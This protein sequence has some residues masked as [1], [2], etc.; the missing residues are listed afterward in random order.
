MT[1]HDAPPESFRGRFPSEPGLEGTFDGIPG[2]PGLAIGKAVVLVRGGAQVPRRSIALAEIE[3]EIARFHTAVTQVVHSLRQVS[4]GLSERVGKAEASILEAYVL[5]MEDEMLSE[6]VE[7]KIR[8][9]LCGAPWAVSLTIAELAR[10][11]QAAPDPYLRER[12]R[13]F[14]FV[15]ERLQQAFSG[16]SEREALAID[17][18]S[19]IVA[20]DLSPEDTATL[21]RDKVLALVTEVGSR[22]SHTAILARALEI[23]AVVGVPNL[24]SHVEQNDVLIVDG[25]RGRVSVSPTQSAIDVALSRAQKQQALAR[26][27]RVDHDKPAL[28]Q[29]GSRLH[30][31]ANIELPEEAGIAVQEGAEGVGLYR[32]EFLYV[33]RKEPPSEDE[34]Y[35]LYRRVLEAMGDRP[36]TLRTFDLGGDK[37]ASLVN[38][39]KEAN[40]ALGMRAVRISLAYQDVFL[41][42][43][44]AMIRA[45]AHGPVQVMVPMISH[46]EELRRVSVLFNRAISE[47]DQEGY[48]RAAHVPL[49]TMIEVPAAALMAD[50]F[51]QEAE[52]MCVGT[53]DLVQYTL[54]ADRSSR[55]VAEIASPFSPAILHLLKNTVEAAD[56]WNRPLSVCGAMA[57]DPFAMVLLLG[58]GVRDI[59]MEAS[60]IGEIKAIL[61]RITVAEAQAASAQALRQKSAAEV[62]GALIAQFSSRFVDLLM[63]E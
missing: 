27:L 37:F 1:D 11:L 59:S 6:R 61:S 7:A 51:A 62:E 30:I 50:V 4:E 44:R 60:A 55:E 10:Q 52:F 40:P 53:N 39:P 63:V 33:D 23:P 36:V 38:G 34:Q 47:V 41:S 57:S 2:S 16:R 26:D 5:M 58:L 29:C 49:G 25:S 18:P 20:H 42:Q 32:T 48:A 3:T 28:T 43:L 22:T 14:L 17:Q 13:D 24:L 21:N 31:R 8:T 19:I 15:G 45:S 9:E 46:I 12:S 54:A 35:E 56:R